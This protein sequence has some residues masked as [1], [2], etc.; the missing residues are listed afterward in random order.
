MTA[1]DQE[2]TYDLIGVGFGPSNLALTIAIEETELPIRVKFLEARP[3][4]AWHPGMMIPGADMQ[5]SFLKDLVS[6]RNPQS[7]YTFVNYL[8]EKGRMNAFINRK[9]FFPSRVEFNDYLGWVAE[10]L[11]H[12]DYDRRV[13]GIEPVGQ[14]NTVGA[15]DVLT[16]DAAGG[17]HSYR[18]RN[19]V[20]APGG[21]ARL[22]PV[23]DSLKADPRVLHSNDYMRKVVPHLRP[24]ERI[25]VVGAGQSA[26]EIFNDLA[27]RPEAPHV[28]LILRGHAMKPSDDSPFVNEIFAPEQTDAFHAMPEGARAALRAEL[29]ATNYAVVDED[30]I[31]DI[32]TKLYEQSVLGEGR[33]ALRSQT[34]IAGLSDSGARLRLHFE[35]RHGMSE[36]EYDRVIFATGY[37]RQ[38]DETVLHGIAG[39]CEDFRTGRDY[40]LSMKDGFSPA[41]FVQ[42]Y[43][44]VSH[45]LSDTLL[46]VLAQRSAEIVETLSDLFDDRQAVA[47]E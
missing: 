39:F 32:Y 34:R 45:G 20:I 30:L 2:K 10:Q 9:T 21:T 29:S 24:G 8:H 37:L 42:G 36:A 6:Q 17:T 40:R 16:Q 13:V 44:E 3:G 5:I 19:L 23:C 7:R 22:P 35:H 28:D 41:V 33:L 4:F 12:C 47:A 43:S 1:T 25:A 11:G 26:A 15:V 46:S 14:G 38:L 18:A 31:L 27:E